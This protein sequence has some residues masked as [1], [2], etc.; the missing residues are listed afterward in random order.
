MKIYYIL[1]EAKERVISLI[2]S[3]AYDFCTD[4]YKEIKAA[5]DN[6]DL[7]AIEDFIQSIRQVE[8]I[9]EI[10]VERVRQANS[11]AN[12]LL[13][14]SEY[15]V[16]GNVLFECQDQV[17]IAIFQAEFVQDYNLPF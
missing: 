12:I 11:V 15:D 13:Y 9:S 16:P 6:D 4:M 7:D 14:T 8:E 3:N 10:Q 1:D 17:L 2:K 5:A